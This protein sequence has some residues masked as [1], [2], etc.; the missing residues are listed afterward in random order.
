M[1]GWSPE[2]F[3]KPD[4]KVLGHDRLKNQVSG[5]DPFNLRS[6]EFV[7]SK[8]SQISFYR[9]HQEVGGEQHISLHHQQDINF[10]LSFNYRRGKYACSSDKVQ[11][12]AW[13]NNTTIFFL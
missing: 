10:L 1:Y 5:T 8:K 2:V 12:M 13:M 7:T 6:V 11:R 3:Q 4:R 9:K